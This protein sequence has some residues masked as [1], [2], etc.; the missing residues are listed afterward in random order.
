M[1]RERNA[2]AAQ[3]RQ[4]VAQAMAAQVAGAQ[5]TMAMLERLSTQPTEVAP[6]KD[7]R[8]LTDPKGLDRLLHIHGGN[9]ELFVW[10]QKTESEGGELLSMAEEPNLLDVDTQKVD[11]NTPEDVTEDDIGAQV[12]AVLMASIAVTSLAKQEDLVVCVAKFQV[13]VSVRSI[14]CGAT[15]RTSKTVSAG[16]ARESWP[17]RDE[18]AFARGPRSGFVGSTA[19]R[20]SCRAYPDGWQQTGGLRNF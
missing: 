14:I 11:P 10:S 19:C 8:Q 1:I 7:T 9:A 4:E 6:E 2:E 12:Y 3:A 18:I 13:R 15:R 5:T 20:G 17:G 16:T